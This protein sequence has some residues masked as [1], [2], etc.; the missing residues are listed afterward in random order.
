MREKQSEASMAGVGPG[1]GT[2]SEEAS[3]A[4][5]RTP[6]KGSKEGQT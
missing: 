3:L 1:S 4:T 6:L 2:D 5:I